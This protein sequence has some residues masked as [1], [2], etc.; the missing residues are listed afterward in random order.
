MKRPPVLILAAGKATRMEPY[1]REM[2]KCLFELAPGLAILDLT[3]RWL[4]EEKIEKVVVVT[5]PSLVEAFRERYGDSI[6]VVATDEEE[7][8]G[9]LYSLR[10]GMDAL[11][12]EEFLLL[13]SDH[14][15]EPEILRR[16]LLKGG[17]SAF[18]LCLDRNPPWEKIE[19]GLKV[20]VRDGRVEQVG[21]Q[22]PPYYGVDTGLFYCSAGARKIVDE[23][24]SEI[25]PKA[26]VADA[27]RRAIR[28]GQ[29]DYVDVTGLLWMDIDTPEELSEARKMLPG[30]LRRS[31]VKPGDGPVSRFLNRPVSTRISVWLFLKGWRVSANLVSVISFLTC[32]AGALMIPLGRPILAAGL[33]HGS[34]ILDGLDGE[35]ARLFQRAS[36]FGKVFD[37]FLDRYADL[38]IVAAGA[39]AL[40]PLTPLWQLLIALAAGNVFITSYVSHLAGW[41]EHPKVVELRSW[42]PAG[43]DARLLVAAISAF[44]G[45]ID[46]YLAYMASVPLLFSAV[47][48]AVATREPPLPKPPA[49]PKREPIPPVSA[50][51]PRKRRLRAVEQNLGTLLASAIKLTLAIFAIKTAGR[52]LAGLGPIPTGPF[53]LDPSQVLSF[54]ELIAVVYFGYRILMAL[55]FFVDLMSSWL[56]RRIGVVT[57]VAVKRALV[58]FLYLSF[59]AVL[60]WIAP[61]RLHTLPGVG[62]IAERL[63]LLLLFVFFV[64]IVYDLMKLFY[65][66]FRGVYD[67]MVAR[68]AERLRLLAEEGTEEGQ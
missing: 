17:A 34:S 23:T 66:S 39:L 28:E 37:A 25:G 67:R 11:E 42:S 22:A 6:E 10:V 18:T 1:S 50:R 65:R 16:L 62:E 24:I 33:I 51:P 8:F 3:L 9:N 48:I 54:L 55:K 26:T 44:L 4:K 58:D 61:P 53:E 41:S 36:R 2:P 59:L 20:V 63:V 35:V 68:L 30:I 31:L 14:I 49:P 13:M 7:G 27:L 15:F 47:L 43:R 46:W 56:V 5:R 12:S 38:A 29:V 52:L 21:K 40:S 60:M 45:R 64:L 57:E 32:L 19:E